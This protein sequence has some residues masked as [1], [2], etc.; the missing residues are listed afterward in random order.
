MSKAEF[1]ATAKSFKKVKTGKYTSDLK[2][3]GSVLSVA[4]FSELSKGGGISSGVTE[5]GR[6]GDDLGRLLS[7]GVQL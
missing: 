5:L 6:G 1:S 4:L 3:L 2:T 7:E